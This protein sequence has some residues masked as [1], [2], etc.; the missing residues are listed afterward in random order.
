MNFNLMKY[1][2]VKILIFCI[3][4]FLDKVTITFCNLNNFN[5]D[6]NFILGNNIS[7]SNENKNNQTLISDTQIVGEDIASLALWLILVILIVPFIL[8]VIVILFCC[9]YIFNWCRPRGQHYHIYSPPLI[10]QER[11]AYVQPSSTNF[12]A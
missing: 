5:K 9:K 10:V 1:F 11:Q 6:D 8:L 2:E 7:I 3:F 12:N 4:V